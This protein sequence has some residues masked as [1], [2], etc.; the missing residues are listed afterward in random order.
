MGGQSGPDCQA[1]SEGEG[2]SLG[3]FALVLRLQCGGEDVRSW[4]FALVQPHS[5]SVL[6]APSQRAGNTCGEGQRAGFTA[7]CCRLP[8]P[9]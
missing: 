3:S 8:S 6:P 9:G 5:C 4:L 7:A 1:A 2:P